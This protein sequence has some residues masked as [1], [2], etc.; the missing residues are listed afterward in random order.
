MLIV[1]VVIVLWVLWSLNVIKG[2]IS[3][4]WKYHPEI[5][6]FTLGLLTMYLVSQ[7]IGI[8]SKIN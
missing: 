5:W 4:K 8:L 3:K 7:L 2:L 1:W 6:F